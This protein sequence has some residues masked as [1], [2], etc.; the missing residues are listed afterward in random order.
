[1]PSRVC[2]WLKLPYLPWYS[3]WEAI[4]SA[5]ENKNNSATKKDS[6]CQNVTK[7]KASILKELI[8]L[9]IFVQTNMSFC[10]LFTS[11]S[12]RIIK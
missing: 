6:L 9:D 8:H 7:G 10:H 11:I 1:M 4:S 3:K 5:P 12:K 2:D